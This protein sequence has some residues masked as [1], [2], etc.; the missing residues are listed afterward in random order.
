M[1][2]LDKREK[3]LKKRIKRLKDSIGENRIEKAESNYNEIQ[4]I[5]KM[6]KDLKKDRIKDGI[7]KAKT[8]LND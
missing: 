4:V 2:D 5:K 7:E 3:E 1:D 8:M 6:K